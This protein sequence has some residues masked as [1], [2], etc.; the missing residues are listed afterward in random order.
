MDSLSDLIHEA[1]EAFKPGL[2]IYLYCEHL[3][4]EHLH[5]E[6]PLY[7]EST[8]HKRIRYGANSL[9]VIPEESLGTSRYIP[10]CPGEDND[11][12]Y[13]QG[14]LYSLLTPGFRY[15]PIVIPKFNTNK[16]PAVLDSIQDWTLF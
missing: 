4:C 9:P 15:R 14:I 1:D 7:T 10:L 6:Q 5:C 16:G 13:L 2:K 8:Y 12:F 11:Y 3:H